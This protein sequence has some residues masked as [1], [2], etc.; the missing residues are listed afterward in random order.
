MNEKKKLLINRLKEKLKE[1]IKKEIEEGT[2]TGAVAAPSTPFAFAKSGKGNERA[3]TAS[4]DYELVKE[5]KK[6]SKKSAPAPVAKKQAPV[7]KKE[8][9]APAPAPAKKTQ[10]DTKITTGLINKISRR[11]KENK[12][13][14]DD[15]D[16]K[17]LGRLKDLLGRNVGRTLEEADVQKM[18]D[19]IQC[20]ECWEEALDPV[21]KED[22]DIN[23]DGKVDRI[24]TY[25]KNRREKIGQS[26][27][28]KK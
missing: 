9:P 27:K 17:L 20:D 24:D 11:E 7:A 1:I 10:D 4:T 19:E 3:A 18:I 25:L 14:G 26:I 28:N 5:G 6:S 12:F 8:A 13:K 2:G 23:N 21:G 22:A 15:D 16:V